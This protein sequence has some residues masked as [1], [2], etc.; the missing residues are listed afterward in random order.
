MNKNKLKYAKRVHRRAH[1]RK[2]VEGKPDRPR[3]AVYRSLNHFYAQIID[4]FRGNTLVAAS[5]RDKDLG[6]S[7][8]GD[9]AAAAAVGQAIAEKAKAAGITRV[10]FDRGGFL[11]HGRVKAM[12]DAARKNGLE[13]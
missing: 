5:T 11:Y 12:A 7:K 9:A 8:T 2:K 6:L 10:V 4:D 3:L 13:F 1:I